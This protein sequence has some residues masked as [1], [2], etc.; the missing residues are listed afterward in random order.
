M[1]R[2]AKA[3]AQT[4]V[5]SIVQVKDLTA[6]VNLRPSPT[7]VN[8]DQSALLLNT[9]I[10][11]KGELGVYPGGRAHTTPSL[12]ARRSQGGKRI[13]LKNNVTFSLGAD[14][15]NIYRP[16]DAGGA[17]GAAVSTGWN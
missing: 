3:A 11:S 9:L 8:P 4:F 14:N 5:G 12:A 13:Y 2:K 15:G 7:N 6:G 17:F 1:P 16:P 10:S